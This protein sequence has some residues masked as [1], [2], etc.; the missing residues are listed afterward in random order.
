MPLDFCPVRIGNHRVRQGWEL[1]VCELTSWA[2][3]EV[4]GGVLILLRGNLIPMNARVVDEASRRTTGVKQQFPGVVQT[5]PFRCVVGVFPGKTQSPK[6]PL[7]L[8]TSPNGTYGLSDQVGK[9]NQV[10]VYPLQLVPE[11]AP[12]TWTL[13]I[14]SMAEFRHQE[15]PHTG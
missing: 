7:Q 3:R 5:R 13:Q 4:N 8:V 15:Q 10:P 14:M 1:L 2:H 11:S 12:D 6:G 9:P